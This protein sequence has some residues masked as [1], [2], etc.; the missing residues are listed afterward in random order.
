[1]AS[2]FCSEAYDA[3]D[4]AWNGRVTVPVLWDKK[5]H[6][7]VNNSEDDICRMF[8]GA[9]RPLAQHHVDLFPSDIATEQAELSGFIYD[10][11]NNGVYS[12]G[13]ATAGSAP[14]NTP[15]ARSST[16]SMNSRCA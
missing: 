14:T 16:R 1:M 2:R 3:T 15:A 7:I 12:A 5:T 4:P 13:F 10:N 6:R 8:N 11:V 9:F